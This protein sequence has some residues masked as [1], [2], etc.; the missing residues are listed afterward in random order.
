MPA[1]QP[2]NNFKRGY[3]VE[4]VGFSDWGI[5]TVVVPMKTKLGVYMPGSDAEHLVWYDISHARH[6]LKIIAKPQG[7]ARATIF[8]AASAAL[9]M[10][11]S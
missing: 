6:F 1:L 8:R 5:G 4:D 9:S 11:H 2:F 3:Q 7:A 10:D